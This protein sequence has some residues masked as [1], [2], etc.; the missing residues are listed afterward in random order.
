MYVCVYIYIYIQT[1]R[2]RALTETPQTQGS[3]G[4]FEEGRGSE[5]F[6]QVEKGMN[7]RGPGVAQTADQPGQT[8]IAAC[9]QLLPTLMTYI[10]L[11]HII[12]YDIMIQ[13]SYYIILYYIILY[14]TI[15][16]YIIWAAAKVISSAG[17]GRRH[18]LA[19]WG[20][21]I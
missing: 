12:S 7:G 16:Y 13:C 11:Y 8:A 10:C 3:G 17:L 2:S 1:A 4:G 9:G 21:W 5:M 6:R 19:F 18:V 20:I 15:L 14:Y